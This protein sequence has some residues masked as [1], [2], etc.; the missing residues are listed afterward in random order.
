[1]SVLQNTYFAYVVCW[2]N[3]KCEC[4]SEI[5][6]NTI[7][8]NTSLPQPPVVCRRR[9]GL[10]EVRRTRTGFGDYSLMLGRVT[11]TTYL[12]TDMGTYDREVLPVAEWAPFY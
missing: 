10:S 6:Y 3:V 2:L 1:M 9:L 5:K 7:Q 4:V 8:Y 12:S 11:G